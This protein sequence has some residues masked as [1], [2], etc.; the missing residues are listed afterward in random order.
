MEQP[1]DVSEED[2]TSGA[3]AWKLVPQEGQDYG[4]KTGLDGQQR[5][6]NDHWIRIDLNKFAASTGN[7]PVV[8]TP[9]PSEAPPATAQ[10]PA[11]PKERLDKLKELLDSGLIT[12]EDYEVKKQEILEGL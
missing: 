7:Q 8:K 1:S 11:D 4:G 2:S 3:V 12:K 5:S 9:G 10:E 6:T